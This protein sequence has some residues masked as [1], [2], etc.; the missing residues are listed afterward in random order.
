MLVD[1]SLRIE[2]CLFRKIIS[3]LAVFYH[4]WNSNNN[5][6]IKFDFFQNKDEDQCHYKNMG[7][8]V[9]SI[10]HY[11]RAYFNYQALAHG[12]DFNLP[13]DAGYLNVSRCLYHL[14]ENPFLSGASC[15]NITQGSILSHLTFLYVVFCIVRQ[16]A[17]DNLF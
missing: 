16:V 3:D 10:S 17:A 8:F 7:S 14:I 9:V 4:P 11:M 2:L 12:D 15:R 5:H 13:D 1:L 6:V